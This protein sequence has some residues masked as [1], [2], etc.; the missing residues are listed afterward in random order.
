MF[1]SYVR[2][3]EH[4]KII[5]E[6]KLIPFYPIF[7]HHHTYMQKILPELP[8]KSVGCQIK[9]IASLVYMRFLENFDVISLFEECFL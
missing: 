7:H 2:I 1:F 5:Q 4:T 6:H 3:V 8:Q 9:Q